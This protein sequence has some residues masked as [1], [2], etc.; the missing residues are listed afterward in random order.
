M[1]PRNEKGF[2]ALAM[3]LVACAV[4]LILASV[5]IPSI[6]EAKRV[7]T[8][9]AAAEALDHIWIDRKRPTPTRTARMWRPNI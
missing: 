7:S 8:E 4:A 2:A 9:V 1:R 6:V 3:M 5:M